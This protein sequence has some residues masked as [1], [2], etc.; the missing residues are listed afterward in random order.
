V[1]LQNTNISGYSGIDIFRQGGVHAGSVWCAND[2]AGATNNR[3]ALTIAARNAG[4]KVIIVGG[5]YDPVVTG[6]LTVA[7][8]IAKIQGS[9]PHYHVEATSGLYAYVWLNNV[10]GGSG[11][12]RD[13]YFIQNT[14]NTTSNGVS[15]GASY[16]Y[17]GQSQQMEFVWGGTSK[18]QITSAGNVTAA[19]FF[20]SSD[21]RLKTIIKDDYKALGIE[22]VK[23]RL[24]LKDGKEEIGYYAQDL[25]DILPS[26]ISENH[27]GLLNLSYTQVHTAKIA[28]IEDEVVVLKKRVSELEKQLKQ[29]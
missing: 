26:A 1:Y 2:S 22:S 25:E 20:E 11:N 7:G 13:A 3:N 24:Y 28:V 4:E 29:K 19:A 6:G 9:S 8:Q 23:A 27:K 17:F 21:S 18:V 5:G 10:A 14:Y 15:A 16:L 12:N